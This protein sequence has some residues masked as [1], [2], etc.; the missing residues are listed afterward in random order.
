MKTFSQFLSEAKKLSFHQAY[1]KKRKSLIQ[2]SLQRT[3]DAH[4]Q[5]QASR[6]EE[7]RIEKIRKH[8]KQEVADKVER[9]HG[10]RVDTN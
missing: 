5:R 3:K 10:I 6:D 1:E 4:A 2:T 8:A 7:D 9:E